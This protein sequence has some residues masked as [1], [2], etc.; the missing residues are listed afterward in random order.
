MKLIK[1]SACYKKYLKSF[2]EME[3]EIE[4]V[5][6]K[7]IFDVYI[8]EKIVYSF[9]DDFDCDD[10]NI[11]NIKIKIEKFSKNSMLK[12]NSGKIGGLGNISLEEY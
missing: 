6:Q 10:L 11:S 5:D 9:S 7:K 12:N 8:D 2:K 3:F 1:S 4:F